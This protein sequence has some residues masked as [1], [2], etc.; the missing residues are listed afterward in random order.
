MTRELSLTLYVITFLAFS[1]GRA[2]IAL[3]NYARREHVDAALLSYHI[4]ID[5]MVPYGCTR[6]CSLLSVPWYFNSIDHCAIF[7]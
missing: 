1:A 7:D 2:G 5:V 3:L 6:E 4:T